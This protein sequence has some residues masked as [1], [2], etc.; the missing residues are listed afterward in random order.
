MCMPTL[1]ELMTGLWFSHRGERVNGTITDLPLLL[2]GGSFVMV[3][4]LY[5]MTGHGVTHCA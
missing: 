1:V 2:C 5:S 4:S 3:L